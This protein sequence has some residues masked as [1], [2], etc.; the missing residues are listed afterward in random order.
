MDKPK[1]RRKPRLDETRVRVIAAT[2]EREVGSANFEIVSVSLDAT[3]RN[4]W[5]VLVKAVTPG[6]I[7]LDGGDALIIVNDQTGVARYYADF[8]REQADT[9]NNLGRQRE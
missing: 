2:F 9:S 5:T 1:K 3:N 8:V 4:E 6:T 7:F